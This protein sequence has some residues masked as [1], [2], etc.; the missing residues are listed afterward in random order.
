MA[1]KPRCSVQHPEIDWKGGVA[2]LSVGDTIA[3]YADIRGE[4]MNQV[5]A[6]VAHVTVLTLGEW[7]RISRC[8]IIVSKLNLLTLPIIGFPSQ[9][10]YKPRCWVGIRRLGG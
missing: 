6:S 4:S 9:I 10:Y 1:E 3:V 7:I 5:Q 8:D 2:W